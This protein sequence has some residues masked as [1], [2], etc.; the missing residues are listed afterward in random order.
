[1]TAPDGT[2][3]TALDTWTERALKIF[4]GGSGVLPNGTE[5][6]VLDSARGQDPFSEFV[7]H[8]MEMIAILSTGGTLST[9]GGSTGLGSNLADVQNEQFQSLI[10]L[11]CK[12]I[13]NAM[14][15]VT[16]PKIL[17]HLGMSRQLCRFEFTEKDDIKPQDY[18]AMAKEAYAMGMPIDVSEFKKLTGLS[19]IKTTDDGES[20]WTPSRME[21]PSTNE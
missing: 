5:V 4:E 20:V 8:Q 15:H 6:N 7:R 9:I 12:K 18:M 14:S 2:P 19:F 21:T 11:D 3:D 13:S 1:M 17:L 10:N 16:I